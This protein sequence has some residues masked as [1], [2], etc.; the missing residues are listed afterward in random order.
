MKR[1]IT[2]FA[3]L[4]ALMLGGCA[5]LPSGARGIDPALA[6]Q[7]D[8]QIKAVQDAAVAACRFLP[9]AQTV[10][11]IASTFLPG[12]TAGV[13]IANQ[14]ATAICGAVTKKALNRSAPAPRVNGVL[15]RGTFI[16]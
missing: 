8:A 15:V 11:S 13:G 6:S 14:I 10:A 5:T 4:G 2:C 3:L 7:I 16:R 9:T 1:L 12:A